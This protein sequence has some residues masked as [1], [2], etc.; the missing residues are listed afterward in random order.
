MKKHER[1][2]AQIDPLR[3][4]EQN[5][6]VS[7]NVEVGIAGGW[8]E[9]LLGK[10]YSPQLAD[11]VGPDGLVGPPQHTKAERRNRH[12]RHQLLV[13]ALWITPKIGFGRFAQ[14]K[15]GNNLHHIVKLRFQEVAPAMTVV[16]HPHRPGIAAYRGAVQSIVPSRNHARHSD[17][18]LDRLLARG[19]RR[20]SDHR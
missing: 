1:V 12:P 17:L 14:K 4:L 10:G 3:H 20:N 11:H 8:R 15:E 6:E 16:L 18:T 9:H 19:L 2:Y 7:L 13:G 5:A